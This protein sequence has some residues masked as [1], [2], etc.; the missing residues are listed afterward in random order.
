[1]EV[2]IYAINH[3][4]GPAAVRVS[5]SYLVDRFG[6]DS[7]FLVDGGSDSLMA[8]DEEKCGTLEVFL[9]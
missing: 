4:A 8:G 7:I 6:I 1:M 2:P 3:S 5:Y 9:S